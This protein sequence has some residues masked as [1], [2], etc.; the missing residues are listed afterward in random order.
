MPDGVVSSQAG[1]GIPLDGVTSGGGQGNAG[2]RD[3]RKMLL[4][5]LLLGG[6]FLLVYLFF[7]FYLMARLPAADGGSQGLRA[8]GNL[9]YAGISIVALALF[10]LLALR[11]LRSGGPAQLRLLLRPGIVLLLMLLTSGMVFA[12]INRQPALPIDIVE[13]TELQNLTAPIEITY[14][15]EALRAIL[16]KQ[17]L[18]PRK[19]SWDFTSDGKVDA[20]R[21]EPEVTTVYRRKGSYAVT[22]RIHLTDGTTKTATRRIV[23]PSAVFGVQPAR[24]IRG[25][26]VTFDVSDLIVDPKALEKILWD[27]NGDGEVDAETKDPSVSHTFPEAGTYQAKVVIQDKSGLQETYVRPLT[28]LAEREQPFPVTIRLEGQT[29]GSAPLGLLLTAE[30]AADIRVSSTHWLFRAGTAQ[31]GEEA[32]GE[33]VSH[34]FTAPGDYEVLLTVTDA[35]GRVSEATQ[36]VTV[37]E[38]LELRDLV[39]GGN[40]KPD[41]NRVMGTAPLD[42]RLSAVTNTPFITFRWEQEEATRVFSTEGEYHALYEEPGTFPVLLIAKDADDRTQKLPLEITV[43]PPKSRVAF[44]AVPATG[45]APL[46]VRFDASESFVPEGRIT[47]FS[48]IFNDAGRDEKPQLLGAQVTHRFEK[49]GTYTVTVHALTE[50]GQSYEARKTIVVRSPTLDACVFPSRTV[51]TTPMGV[52]FDASCSTGTITTYQWDFGDGAT[53]EQAQP[54]QDHVYTAPGTYTV[55]LEVS[56]NQGNISQANVTITAR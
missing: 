49:E 14:G 13:P 46:T 25:E 8:F 7:A 15:T 28:I 32:E 1:G 5:I 45:I 42:V 36:S 52:R 4:L 38:P 51:G 37:L 11:I 35:L 39:L 40:P 17:S 6:C 44:T 55:H 20:E 29:K 34:V 41:R 27:F 56:D 43:L 2:E 31:S 47:G 53:S 10:A 48:W 26:D 9:F 50:E 3:P 16:K 19:Y 23:I 22:L 24:P 54:I 21:Q 30:I 12:A 33:R 18:Y